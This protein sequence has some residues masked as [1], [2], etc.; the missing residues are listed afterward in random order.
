MN[1]AITVGLII[2]LASFAGA[3]AMGT[4]TNRSVRAIG[5]QPEAYSK[6][7][8]SFMLALIF[9]ETVIIYALLVVILI[10]FV[11]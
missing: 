2:G 1:T 4:I 11:L 3:I 6:I 7:R 5:K 8:S 9:I 10:I